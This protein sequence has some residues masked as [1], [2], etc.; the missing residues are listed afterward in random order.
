VKRCIAT[1]L[2]IPVEQQRL[3]YQHKRLQDRMTLE[4]CG[5]GN[6]ATIQLVSNRFNFVARAEGAFQF[7]EP[8]PMDFNNLVLP[9]APWIRVAQNNAPEFPPAN[10]HLAASQANKLE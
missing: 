4:E 8:E 6:N 1:Y 5:L 2:S 9:D 3:L 10:P 7:R